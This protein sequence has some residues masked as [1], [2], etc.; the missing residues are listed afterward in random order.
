M[1]HGHNDDLIRVVK[2]N[3]R[4]GESLQYKAVC[5]VQIN[6]PSLGR[7]RNGANSVTDRTAKLCRDR[8]ISL[9]VPSRAVAQVDP[10]LGMKPEGLTCHQGNLELVR[11]G[12][13][14]LVSTSLY[15]RGCHRCDA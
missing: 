6:W 8:D 2:I 9:A 5:P 12:L 7:L 14:R 1:G 13:L 11:A 4:I 15:L 3:Y 10:G